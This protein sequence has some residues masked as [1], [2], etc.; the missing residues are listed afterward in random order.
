MT[1]VEEDCF[2]ITEFKCASVVEHTLAPCKE[3][4]EEGMLGVQ[5]VLS[6]FQQEHR[7]RL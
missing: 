1:G 6:L 5:K 2:L 3:E 4:Q 7:F